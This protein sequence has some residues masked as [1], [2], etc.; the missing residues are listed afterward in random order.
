MRGTT[1]T[2][3]AAAVPV[4]LNGRRCDLIV[5]VVLDH[6]QVSGQACISCGGMDGSMIPVGHVARDP[7]ARVFAHEHC[8]NPVRCHCAGRW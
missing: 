7:M 8:V 3:G 2:V 1:G 6:R 5:P 4:H